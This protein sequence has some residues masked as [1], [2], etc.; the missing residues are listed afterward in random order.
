MNDTFVTKAANWDSPE[1]IN[2]TRKFVDELLSYI[3]PAAHWKVL[4]I[5]TGTGLV[6][7]QIEPFVQSIVLEDTS[8]SM[9]EVLKQKLE[10][11]NKVEILHGEVFDYTKQDID[12]VV[13]C[14]A[15]HHISDVDKTL[16]HLYSITKSKAYVV[17]GDLVTEDGSFH[18]F[19]PIPHKGFDTAEL[20]KQFVQ[21]GFKVMMVK[22]YNVMRKIQ[23][24]NPKH[25]EQFLLIAEKV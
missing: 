25:F 23:E 8:E 10:E 6:G 11:N 4:E 20:S 18:G 21:A 7:L 2:M 9:L 15:F 12:M 3:H 16:H 1:K 17:V 22:V 5:G 24:S 19:E 13:S 14:M